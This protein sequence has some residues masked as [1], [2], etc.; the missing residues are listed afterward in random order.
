MIEE[1]EVELTDEVEDLIYSTVK[2]YHDERYD[3]M[4]SIYRR[5]QDTANEV[6]ISNQRVHERLNALESMI[7]SHAIGVQNVYAEIENM[8]N[9]YNTSC[10]DEA[11]MAKIAKTK[12]LWE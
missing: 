4:D 1:I 6:L 2:K 11:L 9:I 7:H 8:R 10:I 3:D 12:E 5:L